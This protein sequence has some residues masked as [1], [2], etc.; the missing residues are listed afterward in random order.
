LAFPPKTLAELLG[1]ADAAAARPHVES[2]LLGR[3]ATYEAD[4]DLPARRR[5]LLVHLVPDRDGGGV[6]GVFSLVV[7]VTELERRRARR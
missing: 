6:R 3:E 7:D 2:A 1:E 5:T 4:F